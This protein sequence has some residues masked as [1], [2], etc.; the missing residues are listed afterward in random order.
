MSVAIVSHPQCMEHSMGAGHPECP[1]R[2]NAISEQ[3]I[4]SG[5]G[6]VCPLYQSKKVTKEQL[7]AAHQPHY[8]ESLYANAP[9][10]GVFVI[11]A[12]T[13]MMP[14][15]LAAA[16]Y[17][18]GSGVMAVD[19]LMQGAHRSVFCPVRPP[20]HHASKGQAMGF[21]F[22]NNI[23]ISALHAINHYDLKRVLIV[24]FDVHHGNGTQDIVQGNDKIM[25]CSSFQH[26]FYPYSGD[27]NNADNIHN[28][29]LPSA[30]DG[31]AYRLAVAQWFQLIDAYAPQIIFI[32]A[33]FDGH[34]SDSISS[35]AL[36][37]ADYHWLTR[38]LV[39]LADKH[40]QGKVVSML[41]GGY[42][43]STLGGS[44]VAHLKGLL[45]AD[46]D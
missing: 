38:K 31:Q 4:D 22:F 14:Q 12:D 3:L 32:S 11:D 2:L 27:E 23:A 36:H 17:A 37:D 35:H 1:A 26:P 33:G 25:L 6:H 44:V 24:D 19:L 20:G 34:I 41:E 21:C 16:Q 46:M 28:I 43:I 29:A 9:S 30:T 18:A 8:I 7:V 10:Q 42:A 40:A 39:Q 45:R 13:Q 5:L 15:T